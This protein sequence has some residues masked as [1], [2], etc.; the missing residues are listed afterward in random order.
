MMTRVC[1][2][3]LRTS[4]LVVAGYSSILSSLD[5]MHET[6]YAAGQGS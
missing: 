6:C 2:S 3:L 5:I 4:V 1:Y